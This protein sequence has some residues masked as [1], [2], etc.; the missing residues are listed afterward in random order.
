MTDCDIR[1]EV[2]TSDRMVDRSDSSFILY[3]P[4]YCTLAYLIRKLPKRSFKEFVRSDKNLR[5]IVKQDLD[6]IVCLTFSS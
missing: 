1:Y 4:S 6:K 5:E 2:E 3:P